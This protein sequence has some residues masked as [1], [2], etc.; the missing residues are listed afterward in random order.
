[1][2]FSATQIAALL[3]G[4]VQGD[5]EVKLNNLGSIQDS[6]DGYLTFLANPKYENFI[7]DTQAS[8]V[9]VASDFKPRKEITPTLIRVE[10]PYLAF[11]QL[12]EEVNKMRMQAKTGTEQPVYCGEQVS[13]GE[14][15]YRGAFSYIG[16]RSKIG[17]RV[18]IY[19]QVYIGEDVQI[20]DDCI[21]Y[22]GVKI[23]DGSIIGKGCT[24]HA[25]AVIGSDGFGFAPQEDGSYKSIPQMGHVVLEDNVSIGTNTVI[26]CA[27]LQ[28]SATLIGEGTKLDNLIQIGHN[29]TIGAHTVIAAQTGISGSAS[30]GSYNMIGGQVGVAG[31]LQIGNH[32]KIDAQSGIAQKVPDGAVLLGSPAI[33]R[34]QFIRASIVFRK[35][36][37]LDRRIKELEEKTLNLPATE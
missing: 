13:L 26:D 10:N 23:Y 30:I 20:G 34:G 14:G 11:T 33:D 3:G 25:G 9:I 4:D 32:V 17:D 37:E 24:L 15:L 22:P 21:I 35:L 36:P 28:G 5:G 2:E 29:V 27:T 18:K 1:M 16:N 6:V 12:M 7:Y 31:H 19:P 8:A